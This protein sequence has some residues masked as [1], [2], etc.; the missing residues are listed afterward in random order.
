MND[1]AE[2]RLLGE[3]EA[4]FRFSLYLRQRLASE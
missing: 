4:M 2:P 1:K 3:R